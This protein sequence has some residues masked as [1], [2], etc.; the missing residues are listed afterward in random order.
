MSQQLTL[1]GMP[2]T[3]NGDA[4][5]CPHTKTEVRRK[6][7]SGGAIYASVQCLTCGKNVRFVP[8]NTVKFCCIPLFDEALEEWGKQQVDEFFKKRQQRY[9]FNRQ[10][11]VGEFWEKYNAYLQSYHWS[12]IRR[13][14]LER[15]NWCQ[16]CF[17]QAAT[18]AHHLSYDSFKRYGI[19]FAIECVGVCK[20]CHN[21]LHGKENKEDVEP[22]YIGS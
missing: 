15:D 13:Q 22:F 7:I 21:L 10:N 4:P 18:Q 1:F 12:E 8:K 11:H 14:V 6:T 5:K 19:S 20:A 17:E 9:E 2:E 3:E 16:A